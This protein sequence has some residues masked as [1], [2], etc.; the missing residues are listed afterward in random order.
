MTFSS[1]YNQFINEEK[2]KFQGTST[3]DL[4]KALLETNLCMKIKPLDSRYKGSAINLFRKIIA[5][6][7][8]INSHSLVQGSSPSSG[9]FPSVST[10]LSEITQGLQSLNPSFSEPSMLDEYLTNIKVL[11]ATQQT[12]RDLSVQLKLALQ[13]Q[14]DSITVVTYISVLCI[15]ILLVSFVLLDKRYFMSTLKRE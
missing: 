14:V 5:E 1:D 12:V 10:V 15:A 2:K 3:F 7:E 11:V 6:C 8:D 4:L 9:F 13:S